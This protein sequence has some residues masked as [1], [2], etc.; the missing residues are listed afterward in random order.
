MLRKITLAVA[1]CVA[2]L[3]LT[4]CSSSS[5]AVKNAKSSAISNGIKGVQTSQNSISK[6]PDFG[7]DVVEQA[8]FYKSSPG[9]VAL[10]MLICKLDNSCVYTDLVK[11]S[12]KELLDVVSE[13]AFEKNITLESLDNRYGLCD[14]LASEK[15]YV[16]IESNNVTSQAQPS[17][18]SS[19]LTSSALNSS[20]GASNSL[21]S[22][23]N[24]DKSSKTSAD[25]TSTQSTNAEASTTRTE[26]S[27]TS[28]QWVAK[29][30][31]AILQPLE[32]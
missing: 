13:T 3:L 28:I 26:S 12:A 11:K 15:I 1:G 24:D 23:A 8:S 21:P 30:Q 18:T 27:S 5:G 4:S 7:A 9:R 14:I 6:Q 31:K 2:A 16:S 20:N 19:A 29:F 25:S 17:A 22:K 32:K 10:S